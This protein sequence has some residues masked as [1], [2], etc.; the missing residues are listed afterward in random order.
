MQRAGALNQTV[1]LTSQGVMNNLAVRTQS[2]KMLAFLMRLDGVDS[3]AVDFKE[4][5]AADALEVKGFIAKL[6][7][8]LNDGGM[9]R[10]Q[11]EPTAFLQL[12]GG[13][14]SSRCLYLLREAIEQNPE[15]GDAL[16]KLLVSADSDDRL[17]SVVRRR[18]EAFGKA[19]LLSE[20]FSRDR[21]ERIKS[22]MGV[23]DGAIG[24][25]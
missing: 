5:E 21:L 3:W 17:I 6:Q 8:F 19:Q 23:G 14:R 13:L 18:L 1:D 4:D 11:A 15:V 20:I 22:I 25:E 24:R 9:Q 2:A 7:A 16:E 12:M 10:L